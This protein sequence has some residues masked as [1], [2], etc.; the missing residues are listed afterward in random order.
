ML[1]Q[2]LLES[3]PTLAPFT[4][5]S[6]AP[7]RYMT[8]SSAWPRFAQSLSEVLAVLDEDQ[9]LVLS[10]KD[11][12]GYVQFAA[13]GP[14]GLRAEAVSNAFLP[15]DHHLSSDATK[16][17]T[18]LGWAPPTGSPKESATAKDPDGSPNYH[19][20]W[21]RPVPFDTVAQVAVDTLA[22]V[23]AIGHPGWMHYKAFAR[24]GTQI[25][26]PTLGISREPP[27]VPANK[28]PETAEVVRAR[29]LELLRSATSNPELEADREGDIP[30]RIGS[31]AVFV[32][33]FDDPP[34]VRA[35]S[36]VLGETYPNTR[37]VERINGLNGRTMFAKWLVEG[38]V[39]IVAM[40]LFGRDLP[41]D[42]VVD[43]CRIVGTSANQMDEALQDEFGGKTYFG[44]MKPPPRGTGGYL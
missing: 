8:R 32:R 44:E 40:E 42:H 35:W 11:G 17:M 4:A 22:D 20:D 5:P 31:S 33:I 28:K 18:D 39:V 9:F 14:A 41:G 27:K 19:R 30:F 7:G 25:L 43:A 15:P 37:L 6:S 1:I 26:L 10:R 3:S 29:V 38:A 21:A 2:A 12:W 34:V 36:P 13:Q 24:N 23:Y 16:R